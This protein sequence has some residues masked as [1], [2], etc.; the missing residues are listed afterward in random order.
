MKL[1]FSIL[2]T[3]IS[4]LSWSQNLNAKELAK[5]EAA[6]QVLRKEVSYFKMDSL[7][8]EE[9]VKHIHDFIP[10]F[11]AILK[12][13]NSF[14][15]PFDSLNS[16]MKVYAPDSSFRIFTWQLK[17]P[18]GT[19]KYYGALQMNSESL[20]LFPLFD[21]SDTMDVHPQDILSFDNWYG[22]IYYQCLQNQVGGKNYYTL[23]GFDEADFVSNRK[24][25]EFL[26]FDEEGKP[27][28]GAPL[29]SIT[30]SNEVTTIKNRFF[31]EYIDKAS[32]RLNFDKEQNKVIYDHV[33]AP[34][35]AQEGA[36]FTYIPDGTYEGFEWLNSK[37][38][39][40][41][42]IFHYSIGLPDSPPMPKPILD[43]RD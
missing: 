22:A 13:K 18:L 6:E 19:H 14:A 26:S 43:N 24:L 30:D 12:D 35:Q 40:V 23:F 15:Y 29:V 9:R 16:I 1:L 11:V 32:V 4:L 31:V 7:S 34:S 25:M 21:Y 37:W 17:E 28:F 8:F 2:L 5:F 42:K 27:V 36:W 3:S 33:V 38:T 39:W 41:E 20:K 10:R